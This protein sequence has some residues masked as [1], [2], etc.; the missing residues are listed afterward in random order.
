MTRK[1]LGRGLNALLQEV[2]SPA[3]STRLEQIPV[4]SFDPNPLQPRQMFTPASL[5]ELSDSIRASGLVQPVLAR[6]AGNRFQLIAGER[7]WRAATQ[8]GLETI[9]AIVRD[10]PDAEAL[11]IALTENLLRED[12]NPLEVARAYEQLQR[13]FH[14]THEEIARRLGISRSAVTNTLRL[15]DLE[16]EIQKLI[17]EDKLSAGHARA[18]VAAASPG[19]RRKLAGAVVSRGLSVRQLEAMISESGAAPGQTGKAA[20]AKKTDPNVRAAVTEMER[21][22]G[23]R[24]RV[25][26]NPKRGRIEI[27]YY[28]EQDLERIYRYIL[29]Q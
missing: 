9:P 14:L 25:S 1:A 21:A 22:L 6:R 5:K 20:A 10:M 17:L 23:T 18:I 3:A 26:G 19:L 15:L 16:P 2:E 13:Q 27:S 4:S 7:R 12:L 28:S 29:R 11:E 24:V 8:A